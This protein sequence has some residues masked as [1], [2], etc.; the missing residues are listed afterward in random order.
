[1]DLTSTISIK[2]TDR[3]HIEVFHQFCSCSCYY[4]Q[5]NSD[6]CQIFCVSNVNIL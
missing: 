2:M 4:H 5:D 3:L 1:M 6:Y